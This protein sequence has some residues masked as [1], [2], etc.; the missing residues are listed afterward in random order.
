[1]AG[2]RYVYFKSLYE[3]HEDLAVTAETKFSN[4]NNMFNQ[5]I[6]NSKDG[7]EGKTY[8]QS[9]LFMIQNLAAAERKSELAF[10]KKQTDIL[11]QD[12]EF[13]NSEIG[14]K[15]LSL[16]EG[17]EYNYLQIIDLL[18]SLRKD[19]EEYK[20]NLEVAT[21]RLK[22]FDN[23]IK[24][25]NEDEELQKKLIE[26][27]KLNAENYGKYRTL[28]TDVFESAWKEIQDN[29]TIAEKYNNEIQKIF[30]TCFKNNKIIQ[31]IKQEIDL[32]TNII[33]LIQNLVVDYVMD[34]NKIETDFSQWINN[35]LRSK[36]QK[37][38]QET[39]YRV[40]TNK[41]NN[42]SFEEF[43]LTHT[44]K[45]TDKLYEFDE[46][47]REE[48]INIYEG[49]K[50]GP[51]H[52]AYKRYNKEIESI[53]SEKQLKGELTLALN[54][55]FDK[56][57]QQQIKNNNINLKDND[58]KNLT[59][60][61]IQEI[62][63]HFQIL[64]DKTSLEHTISTT[65][66]GPSSI[67]ELLANP[68][69]VSQ[70]KEM[71]KSFTPGN[72]MN[73]KNDLVFTCNFNPS[74]LKLNKSAFNFKQATENFM[75]NFMKRYKKFGGGTTDTTA[76]VEAYKTGILDLKNRYEKA[77]EEAKDDAEQKMALTKLLQ[78]TFFGGVSVKEYRYISN[79]LGFHG[80][81][82]G[83]GGKVINAIPNILQM[84]EAGGITPIDA[85][86]IIDALLNCSNDMIGGAFSP[87]E[88]IKEYLIGGAAML[89]FDEGFANTVPFLKMMQNSFGEAAP[90]VVHLYQLNGSYIPA[91]YILQNIYENL[92]EIIGD[93]NSL[94][95]NSRMTSEKVKS[96]LHVINNVAEE[97]LPEKYH[98][99]ENTSNWQKY[100][101]YAQDTVTIHFLF[102]AGILDIFEQLPNAFNI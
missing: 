96:T 74:Q 58:L 89:M 7:E 36:I 97:S 16:Q 22:L 25:N 98:N 30:K 13:S 71:F 35:N 42:I 12:K 54:H 10:I 62:L 56:I 33:D 85:E 79:N 5:P 39:Y 20:K 77:I 78:E 53:K 14:R 47:I 34:Q 91:S 57:R 70:I 63:N 65:A 32:N 68:E 45:L 31:T 61:Q 21:Q 95:E 44:K 1:M 50:D 90:S 69:V 23:Y 3:T 48:I 40:F 4:I 81:S 76:A 15:I 43:A 75:E 87:V 60:E 8:M 52:M 66:S 64:H 100:S 88:K 37:A 84:Y 92:A 24:K 27:E 102:M 11:K 2:K 17:R 28:M 26:A 49:D 73:L 46:N 72:K 55:A 93:I 101:Q 29:S 18:N 6:K 86:I 67:A 41:E 99:A 51:L 59:K 19:S 94:S 80:G 9:Y 82:L 38:T 83:G